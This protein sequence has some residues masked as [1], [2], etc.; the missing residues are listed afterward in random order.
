[1]DSGGDGLIVARPWETM[2][3]GTCLLTQRTPELEELFIDGVH[4]VMYDSAEDACEK[5][6]ALFAD[7]AWAIAIGKCGRAEV[8]AKHTYIHRAQTILDALG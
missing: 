1:L 5:L 2:G 7:R 6:K 3:L 8:Q 4:C